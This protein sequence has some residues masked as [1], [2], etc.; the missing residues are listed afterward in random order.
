[1]G[2]QQFEGHEALNLSRLFGVLNQGKT[3][4]ESTDTG[5]SIHHAGCAWMR[6]LPGTYVD[7]ACGKRSSWQAGLGRQRLL[8]RG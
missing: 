5:L 6:C 2:N 8:G 3:G 4:G 1:M 7:S